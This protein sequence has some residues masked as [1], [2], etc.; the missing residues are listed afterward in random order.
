MALLMGV[1]QKSSLERLYPNLAQTAV[2]VSAHVPSWFMGT[3][4]LIATAV[5]KTLRKMTS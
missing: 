5:K 1:S 4:E 2:A 3:K